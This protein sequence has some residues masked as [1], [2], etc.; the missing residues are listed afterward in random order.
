[1][2]ISRVLENYNR[3]TLFCRF[4]GHILQKYFLHFQWISLEKVCTEVWGQ[5]S[6]ERSSPLRKQKEHG[7]LQKSCRTANTSYVLGTTVQVHSCMH[8]TDLKGAC[9]CKSCMATCNW[10]HPCICA[11]KNMHTGERSV[12]QSDKRSSGSGHFKITWTQEVM[13]QTVQRYTHPEQKW[14]SG[15]HI[16]AAQSRSEQKNQDHWRGKQQI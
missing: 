10:T 4:F 3:Q 6:T 2:T 11:Q 15:A 14:M 5:D 13:Y 8:A 1:M 16:N 7:K 12:E 9:K